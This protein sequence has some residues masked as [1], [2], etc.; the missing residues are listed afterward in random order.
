M[1]KSFSGD[2]CYS[3]T[4][5]CGSTSH[6]AS[7]AVRRATARLEISGRPPRR[8]VAAK[9]FSMGESWMSDG[10][11]L[12]TRDL[13]GPI[14]RHEA[15]GR[16]W[17]SVPA[18]WTIDD[19]QGALD[20]HGYALP[21]TSNFTG[22]TYVG[23][24]QT[25]SHGCD[26][27]HGPMGSQVCAYEVVDARG[28]LSGVQRTSDRVLSTLG[29]HDAA[30]VTDDAL[31]RAL[32]VSLGALGVITKVWV[33]AVPRFWI[34]HRRWQS[35]WDHVK[36]LIRA[37]EPYNW[38]SQGFLLSPYRRRDGRHT[39]SIGTHQHL[40]APDAFVPRGGEGL[41][42]LL[43]QGMHV[44]R[45]MPLFSRRPRAIPTVLEKGFDVFTRAHEVQGSAR[46]MLGQTYYGFPPRG[47]GL[48]LAV[49]YDTPDT[50]DR[51]VAF[52]DALLEQIAVLR[53]SDRFVGG[54]VSIRFARRWDASLSLTHGSNMCFV[55]LLMLKGTPR[56]R[57]TLLTL[58]QNLRDFSPRAHFGL[59]HGTTRQDVERAYP[60]LEEFLEA[61][62]RFD[63][64]QT[65]ANGLTDRIGITGPAVR[66]S[67]ERA[68]A[69]ATVPV[70]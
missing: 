11:M 62:E 3:P 45:F 39:C 12:D 25:S 58:Q 15:D 32:G 23:A 68:A 41:V 38:D 52:I 27:H 47:I 18:G 20:R 31:F 42:A 4:V 66:K 24:C 59:L 9:R 22:A 70:T 13:R 7:A 54:Y 55:E 8:H 5:S 50:W 61:R 44:L 46:D 21:A 53:R 36:T 65:F 64:G 35:T 60:A 28:M 63:P 1:L 57:D 2:R 29:Y 51:A 56:G 40:P 6:D 48:E 34:L 14:E 43:Q 33:A 19:V 37:G 26:L 30:I 67:S 49:P 16:V 17:F 10:V 69:L